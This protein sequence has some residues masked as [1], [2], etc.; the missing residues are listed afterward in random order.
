MLHCLSRF[1]NAELFK[2]LSHKI[3]FKKLIHV[4]NKKGRTPFHLLLRKMNKD[5]RKKANLRAYDDVAKSDDIDFEAFSKLLLKLEPNMNVP[6]NAGM[7]CE[8]LLAEY[9]YSSFT[10]S[11]L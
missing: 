9:A 10:G 5:L 3:N 4:Q 6:D 7:T 11:S 2:L 8:R 1:A